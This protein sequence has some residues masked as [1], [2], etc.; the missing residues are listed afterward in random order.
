MAKIAYLRVSTT[1]QNTTRQEYALPNDIDILEL[2]TTDK[3]LAQR[4]KHKLFLNRG[5]ANVSV[6]DIKKQYSDIK[7]MDLWRL[8]L[9]YADVIMAT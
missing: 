2:A 9:G 7:Q 1:H 8:R 4:F 6:H 3:K 5:E